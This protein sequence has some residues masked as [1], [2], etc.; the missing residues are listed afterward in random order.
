MTQMARI[1]VFFLSFFICLSALGGG[2]EKIRSFHKAKQEVL[3]IHLEEP[4]TFYCKALFFEDK[5]LILPE[6]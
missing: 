2:N 6:G 4:Y 3:K 5:R 1:F